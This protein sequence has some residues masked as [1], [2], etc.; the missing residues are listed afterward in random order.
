VE[1][2]FGVRTPLTA[3]SRSKLAVQFHLDPQS[4]AQAGWDEVVKAAAAPIFYRSAYLAA[5]HDYPLADLEQQCYLM[6]RTRPGEPPLAVV[7]VALHHS[8]DPL[9]GL[10]L[11][12]PGIE[13]TPALLSHVWHCYDTRIVG[14]ADRADVA[15]AIIAAMR[16]LASSWRA[17][18]LGFVNVEHGSPTSSALTA[19][20][21]PGAHLIERFSAGL[22]GLTDLDG[23]LARLGRRGRANLARN[24]RRA[25]DSGLTADVVTGPEADL[26]EVAELCARTATRFGNSDFYPPQTFAGFVSGLGQAV[27]I[28]QIR[29]AGRLVAVGV[30]FTDERRFHTWACGVDYDVTGNASPYTL[31]FSESVALAIRLGLPVLEGGR[32]NEVFKRRH[33]LTGRQLDAHVVAV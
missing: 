8:P 4:A 5:Y 7:P 30:C 1:Y 25:A 21:L 14:A 29:Q 6:V 26:A 22:Q 20:G 19:A 13:R 27:Q 11:I 9:G 12:H 2:G 31:L 3:R 33:G 23:F 28:I 10:R 24:A 16:D 17:G 15:A 32:S 18:W